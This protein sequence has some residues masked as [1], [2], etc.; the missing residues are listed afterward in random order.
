MHFPLKLTA[1]LTALTMIL[2]SCSMGSYS[3]GGVAQTAQEIKWGRYQNPDPA[4]VAGM[5]SWIAGYRA[6]ARAAGISDAT[7]DRAFAGV[8][9]NPEVMSRTR[10]QAEFKKSL[11]E[12]LENAVSEKRQ[13]NGRAALAQYG[14]VLSRVEAAYGVD[15][16]VVAAVWGMESTYGERRG[17]MP[18]IEALSTLSY[19][20]YRGSFFRSQ[21]TAALKILQAGDVDAARMTGSWA[22][23]MGHTQFIPTTYLAYAADITGDGRRDIWSNDPSDALASAANYLAK[24]GWQRGLPAAVEVTLPAGF[25]MGLAGKGKRRS[26]ADWQSL[27]IRQANARPLPPGGTPAELIVPGGRSGA[28]FL[29]TRNFHAILR[30]NNAD[31]YALAV[32]HLADRLKGYPGLANP[33]PAD[34]PGLRI[35]Q[36]KE[37]QRL[38]TMRGFDTQGIDG[39]VGSNTIAAIRAYQAARGL[40]V[41]GEP[42]AAL[43]EQL[44][45]G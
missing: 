13:T 14:G 32:S 38:L 5:Q 42:N 21:L 25:N 4:K 37:M 26:V 16:E 30:Y 41:T 1:G 8:T 7:L 34:H 19:E 45:R 9:Y 22:G 39:N 17:D 18:V 33:W 10:N 23:A 12:Y 29:I 24:S 35:E 15:K 6:S 40:P 31:S 28:A 27:G 3:P 44:R 20:N 2:A 36:R 11:W 43:L